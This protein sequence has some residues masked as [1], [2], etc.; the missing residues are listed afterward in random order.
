MLCE[1]DRKEADDIE[2]NNKILRLRLG[3]IDKE[4]RS[5]LHFTSNALIEAHNQ[6]DLLEKRNQELMSELDVTSIK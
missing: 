6:I 4:Y 5:K 1:K 3:D 2:K